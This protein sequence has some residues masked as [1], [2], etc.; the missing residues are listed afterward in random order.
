MLL[1]QR[2]LAGAR[3]GEKDRGDASV[4]RGRGRGCNWVRSHADRK[5]RRGDGGC[6]DGTMRGA[7]SKRAARWSDC[8]VRAMALGQPVSTLRARSEG[9]RALRGRRVEEEDDGR[10]WL[11]EQEMRWRWSEGPPIATRGVA[12]TTTQ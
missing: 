7:P 12:A 9:Q 3:P 2:R 1:V 5:L 6:G 4:E 8:A 11:L 10:L